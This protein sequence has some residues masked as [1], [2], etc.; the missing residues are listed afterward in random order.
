MQKTSKRL[1]AVVAAAGLVA[2]LSAGLA[3]CAN[4]VPAVTGSGTIE[5]ESVR[6]AAQVPGRVAAVKV[7]E[8]D[9]VQAGQ[10]LAELDGEL[11]TIQLAQARIGV[12]LAENQLALLRKGA[13]S[14]DIRQAEEAVRRAEE[15]FKTAQEDQRRMEALFATRSV[16][17]KQKEDA[18]ARFNLAQAER[19]SALQALQKLRNFARPEEL[20]ASRIRLEQAEAAARLVEKQLDYARIDAPRGGTITR[21][22][23]REGEYAMSGTVLFVLDDL[24][25]VD[26]VVYVAEPQVGRVRL[27]Q[28]A[29]VAVDAFPGRVFPAKVSWISSRAEFTP[30]TVQ[31]R[32]ERTTLVFAVKLRLDNPKRELKAGMPADAVLRDE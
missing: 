4:G 7:K 12:R 32:E 23:L 14:E 18:E 24:R 17:Q 30:K 28:P 9:E 15:N 20:E 31:T 1:P 11:L 5:A 10:R 22:V 6:I 16:T 25:T 13:R 21:A 2:G 19:N 26:L 8:G 3:A 29:E 27:G